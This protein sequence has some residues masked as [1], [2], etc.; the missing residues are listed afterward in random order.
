MELRGKGWILAS[1]ILTIIATVLSFI[2]LAGTGYEFIA[3]V[4]II[5]IILVGAC[6]N[7]FKKGIKGW[8][9]FAVVWGIIAAIFQVSNGSFPIG[10]AI[11]LI[12]GIIGLQD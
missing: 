6:Y 1:L 12:G 2:L 5:D 11:L 10:G 4:S 3:L 9:V 8:A 7:G